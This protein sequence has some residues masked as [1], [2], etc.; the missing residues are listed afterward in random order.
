MNQN[1]VMK[2]YYKEFF[3]AIAAYVIILIGSISILK[4]FEFSKTVQGII[5][6]TPVLPIVF[7]IIAIILLS[8]VPMIVEWWKARREAKV[9]KAKA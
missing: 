3:I 4:A 2:R 1:E 6:V 9:E 5:A 7:V 8:V